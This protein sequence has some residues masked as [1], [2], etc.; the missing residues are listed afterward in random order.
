MQICH[1]HQKLNDMKCLKPVKMFGDDI[2]PMP[3]L[4]KNQDKERQ[5]VILSGKVSLFKEGTYVSKRN[6]KK[7]VDE[8][9]FYYS[10]T[11]S[12]HTGK[13]P[14]IYFSSKTNLSKIRTVK[15][16]DSVLVV[17][18]IKKGIKD[19]TIHI[20]SL[21]FC[22]IITPEIK[23]EAESQSQQLLSPD[24]IEEYKIIKPS[25][26]ECATQSNLFDLPKEYNQ[27]F[28]SNKYVVFDVET[29]GLDAQKCEII[30]IGSVKI[31]NG[32]IIEKF[33]TL[34]K[35]NQV[36][37]EEITNLTGIT[38]E[39]VEHSP[40]GLDVIK[41]FYKFC[42]GCVLVGYNVAFDHA[43]IQNLAKKIGYA[44]PNK[45]LDAMAIAKEKLY[46]PKYKLINVVEALNLELNNAHRA[47]ADALATAQVLQKLNEIKK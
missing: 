35:P 2:T 16:G 38:N 10:F 7:G 20:K 29:T 19:L 6:K 26:Y 23:K 42:E 15:D 12:D 37:S 45:T 43:F 41:D 21:S 33:Q 27:E 9:S 44:F 40:N 30:E 28:L 24:H 5:S 17:G 31:E 39:M 32:K 22:E 4:V 14:A 46:L 1:H 47:Y 25:L 3:E 8:K 36:I 18:D 11:I 13:I 34:I